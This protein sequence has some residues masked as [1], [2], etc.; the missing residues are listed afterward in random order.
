MARPQSRWTLQSDTKE[1][2]RSQKATEDNVLCHPSTDSLCSPHQQAVWFASSKDLLEDRFPNPHTLRYIICFLLFS[3]G[4]S[5]ACT[6]H[7]HGMFPA[8]SL[9]RGLLCNGIWLVLHASV[10]FGLRQP[11]LVL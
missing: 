11:S 10:L 1:S 4:W 3:T 5:S 6:S 9:T 2:E 7:L 8:G